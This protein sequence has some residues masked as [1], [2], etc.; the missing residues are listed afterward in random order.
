MATLKIKT[1]VRVDFDDLKEFQNT[2]DSST[3]NKIGRTVKDGIL[4]ACAAG[5]SPVKGFGRFVGYKAQ[6]RSNSKAKS[7]SSPNKGYPYSVMGKYPDKTVRPV[8][9]RLTGDMLD[10]LTWEH[11]SPDTV[12]VLMPEGTLAYLKAETHNEGTQSHIPVRKF[13][14]TGDDEE[15]IVSIQR[16]VFEVMRQRIESILKRRK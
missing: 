9:L 2:I 1:T 4:K 13:L 15:F 5:L 10:S 12:T 6:A 8:N 7:G 16:E 11:K 14:P 3:A